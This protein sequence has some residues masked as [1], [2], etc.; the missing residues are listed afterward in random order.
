M[1]HIN[2]LSKSQSTPMPASDLLVKEAQL[3]VAA[4]AIEVASAFSGLVKEVTGGT[5]AEVE[6]DKSEEE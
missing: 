1:R 6:E 2:L 3:N 4:Q 5:P